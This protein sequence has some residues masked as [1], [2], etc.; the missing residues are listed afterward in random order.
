MA[1]GKSIRI[2]LGNGE[3]AGIRY[4]ELFGW[5]GQAMVVPRSRIAELKDWPESARAGVYLLLGQEDN[6][7]SAVY[8]GE[9]E[10]VFGRIINHLK[11]GDRDFTE[12]ILC[13]SK[14]ENLTKAHVKFLECRMYDEAK[15]S[16]RYALWNEN[17]PAQT[18][19][20]RPDAEAME[21][22]LDN[23]KTLVQTLGYPVFTPLVEPAEVAPSPTVQLPELSFTCQN[24]NITAKGRRTDEGFLVLKDSDAS[25]EDAPALGPGYK[26]L[27]QTLCEQGIL[28]QSGRKL[29][30]S[31]DYLFRS[32]SAAASVISG[33]QAA[34]PQVWQN[35]AGE[36]LK[37]IEAKLLPEV[38][39]EE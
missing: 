23:L 21:E 11:N 4:V 35:A 10:N 31:A 3:A 37:Q 8:I 38:V 13:T 6:G 18:K 29:C 34:G 33:Y 30:F 39:I 7:K 1:H 5:T 22:F 2:Y 12:V 19:L 20:P 24:Q 27:R 25:L 28:I 26:A 9:S 14:D 36:S 17:T 32:P 15:R 16:A